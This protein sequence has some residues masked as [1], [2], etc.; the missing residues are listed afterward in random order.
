LK[1]FDSSLEVYSAGTAPAERIHPMTIQVMKETGIDLS[2]NSPRNIK[3]FLSD[4]FDYV[5]T[6]CDDA[7]ETCPVFI[8]EVKNRLHIG[9][10]DPAKATGTKEEILAVFRT[11]RDR[12]KNE[13]HRF[14]HENIK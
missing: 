11:I 12:I 1:S 2:G 14:Y 7:K 8:G 3:G 10:N 5:I 9:F 4:T 6:V 13:F